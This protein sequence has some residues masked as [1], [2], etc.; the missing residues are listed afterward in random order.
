MTNTL[1]IMETFYSIQGEGHF[2]GEAAFFIRLAGCDVGCV[3][4]DVKESWDAKKHSHRSIDTLIHEVEA[5]AAKIVI[6]TGGEPMMYDCAKLSLALQAKGFKTH[7]E[8]SGAYPISG[9]WDW[10][11]IS[12]KKFKAPLSESLSLAQELKVVVFNKSDFEWATQHATLVQQ[13]CLLFL[14]PE[15]S[16]E[17]EILPAITDFVQCNPQWKLSL[18][19]HKYMNVR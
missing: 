2:Q 19:I 6:V 7:L 17:K 11:C 18:Q 16:K 13:N 9:S 10:I 5:T 14:Q 8:T 1:P 12:P 4:C 3:W 15:W